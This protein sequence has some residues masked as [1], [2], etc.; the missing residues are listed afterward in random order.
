[1]SRRDYYAAQL[2]RTEDP[3]PF[4]RAHSG[5]PRPRGNLELMQAAADIGGEAD[6]RLWIEHGAGDGPTDEFLAMRGI[7]GFG[8]LAAEGRVDLVDDLRTYAPAARWRIREAVVM[9]LQR[10][11]DRDLDQLLRI[12]NGWAKD[13]AYVQRAGVAA[14]SEPRFLKTAPV[15]R[16]AP[17]LVDRVTST[18]AHMPDKRS[19]ECRT[20]RQSLG[21]CWSVV[22]VAALN[23][24]GIGWN[25][26]LNAQT[27]TCVGLSGRI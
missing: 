12:A 23:A 2:K 11:G 21:Y 14:V 6:F 26:G 13:R 1:M 15:V 27:P 19:D 7:V 20:L 16:A 22:T 17:D 18:F 24:A 9:A 8:R 5:L 10:V 25:T 3:L 4:L